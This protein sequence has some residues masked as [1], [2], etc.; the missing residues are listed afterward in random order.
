MFDSIEFK[1]RVYRERLT[2][3]GHVTSLSR[4]V[5]GG[6]KATSRGFSGSRS[7]DRRK[8][9]IFH[10]KDDNGK[11]WVEMIIV[12]SLDAVATVDVAGTEHMITCRRTKGGV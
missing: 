4:H 3:G 6:I 5:I 12:T 8:L 1:I 10:V 9:I 11:L 2:G 7:C